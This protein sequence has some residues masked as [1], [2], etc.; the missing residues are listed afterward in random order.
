MTSEQFYS[1][2]LARLDAATAI[3]TVGL[4]LLVLLGAIVAGRSM[5]SR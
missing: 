1:A 3:G 2:V 5:W 4:A